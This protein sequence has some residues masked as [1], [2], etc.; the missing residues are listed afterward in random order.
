MHRLIAI[1]LALGITASAASGQAL[2]YTV[3]LSNRDGHTFAVTLRVDSLAPENGVIAFAATAPGTYQVMDIGRFVK[4]LQAF[5]ERGQPLGAERASTNQWRISQPRMVREIRYTVDETW[6]SKIQE[7][8]VYM[9]AGT[10]LRRDFALI[11]G[12]AVFGLPKGMQAAPISVKLLYPT[13][14]LAATAMRDSSGMLLSEN[15]DRLVDSPVLLGKIT[16][17][18]MEV[19]GVPVEIATYSPNGNITSQELL[20]SMRGML[21]AAGAFIGKLPVDRYVFLFAFDVP[22]R[23]V[24]I[25]Y[26]AWEHSYSSEY[27]LPE[28]TFSPAFGSNVADIASHEFFHVITPLNIHSEII[29]HFNFDSPVPSRHLWLYEGV[30]EWAAHKM[31][32]E[33]GRKTLPG[34]LASV[35]QKY[36]AD[37]TQFD[38]TY[39]LTKLALTSYSDSGQR[40]Y[41]TIYQKGAIVAGLLDIRLLELSGAKIGLKDLIRTLAAKY[42]KHQPFPE[43]SLVDVIAAATSP[44]VREFFTRYVDGAESLPM[45]EYYAKVGI[46]ARFDGKGMLFDLVPS[47]TATEAQLRLRKAWLGVTGEG[48]H[49]QP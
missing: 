4:N 29:E 13:G 30:T 26:G 17:A 33:S 43:D 23:G 16:T 37:R 21:T 46:T 31:Q 34:Y 41:P 42:G 27:V 25:A 38:T 40:Q 11:N 44:E 24:P 15:Y 8:K 45:A 47:A 28:G 49:T 36:R 35:V 7:H 22:P 12:Q 19:M 14:W 18:R 48:A 3:D 6:G 20:E 5:D 9:M 2:R 39:S 1:G 32:L 10:A